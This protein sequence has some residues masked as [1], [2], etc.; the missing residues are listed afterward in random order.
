[1]NCHDNHHIVPKILAL[2]ICPWFANVAMAEK[3]TVP[4]TKLPVTFGSAMENTP[5]VFRGRPLLALNYRDDTKHNTDGYKASMYLLLRD[6]CTGREVARFGDGHS[7]VNAIVDGPVLHVFASEGSNQDWF[8][9]IY[10]FTSIGPED[11]ET[12]IGH[13]AEDGE[14][15]FN[16]SVCRDDQ[17]FLMAY[18][19]NLPVPF[20]FKFARSQDLAK[21]DKV[22]GLVYAGVDGNEYSAC[23][24]IRYLARITTSST[25]TRPSRATT[26]GYRFWLD[27]RI[28]WRGS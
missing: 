2:F 7:F 10:H 16:C 21:W 14:H 13:S 19:S 17:G 12:R 3:P 5:L 6:L 15:L 26:V 18:E 28:W 27:P 23:P 11:V 1:M 4:L 8:Q 25:C 20:C 9:S 24:V 22:P